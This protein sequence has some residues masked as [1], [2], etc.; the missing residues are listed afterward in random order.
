M[1][2][3]LTFRSGQKKRWS[4]GVISSRAPGLYE[5]MD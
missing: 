3:R 5:R 2:S 1:A 4:R